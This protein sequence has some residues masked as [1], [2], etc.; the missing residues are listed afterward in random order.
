MQAG[1][2]PAENGGG[3]STN[4]GAILGSVFGV[5]G[6][7]LVAAAVFIYRRRHRAAFRTSNPLFGPGGSGKL[8]QPAAHTDCRCPA[9]HPLLLQR[10]RESD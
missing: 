3:S 2:A 8:P 9:P 1:H 5:L 7:A 6:A 4:L 10:S